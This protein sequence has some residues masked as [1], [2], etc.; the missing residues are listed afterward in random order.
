MLGGGSFT[1]QNKTLP[2]AYINFV[3]AANSSSALSERGIVAVPAEL[4]W[5]PEKQVIEL[6]AEDFSRDMRKV[7]GY[8]RDAAE[9]RNLREVFRKATK[10]LIYRLNGGVKAQNDLAEARYSGSRGNDLTVVV[11]ANVDVKSSFDVSTLLDGRE[12]DKQTVAG[13]GA[14]KDNDYLVWKKEGVL[15][16]T[17]G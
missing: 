1:A 13:I 11:T 6:T 9:M 5:G 12:V 17:A 2:G 8:A 16:Q 15:E 4:G 3:S 7:L 10:C 14:L